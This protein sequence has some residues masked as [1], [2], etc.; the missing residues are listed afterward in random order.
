MSGALNRF[1][2]WWRAP[3]PAARLALVRALVGLYCLGLLLARGPS[4][5]RLARF[6]P[7][8]F[9]PVGVVRLLAA[10]LPSALVLALLG[11]ALVGALLF[12]LGWRHRLSAPIFALA[13]LLVF[14][15]RNSWGHMSHADHLVVI[16]VL[17]LAVVPAADTLSLDARAGRAH[18]SDE[19]RY[20]WPLRLLMLTVVISYMLAGWAKIDHGGWAWIRGDALRNQIA[21]DTLR[22]LRLGAL[23][24]PVSP[25]LLRQPWLFGL[26]APATV[27]IE[28]GGLVAMAEGKLR[29]AWL[30]SVWLMH[31]GIWIAMG[32]GFPYPLSGVAFA[33][34]LPLERGLDRLRRR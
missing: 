5:A 6:D 3:A 28:L 23:P 25:S 26:F 30:A 4:I 2:A 15:Y 14:S 31:V 34:F 9:E 33:G 1:D 20:G 16:H 27:V 21:H 8:R 12:M 11:L 22:K 7:S 10:P 18:A 19:D 32:I 29:H 13:L 24:S 17:I